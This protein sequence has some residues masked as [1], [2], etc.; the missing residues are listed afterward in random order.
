MTHKEIIRK[1]AAAG[2]TFKE[3]AKHTKVYKDGRRVTQVPR[4]SGDINKYTVD[5]IE[6]ST[7]V[8]LRP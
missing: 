2:F 1:L 7:G 8:K 6:D 4:G 3:G 5:S